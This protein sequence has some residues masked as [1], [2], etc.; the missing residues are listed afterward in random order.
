MAIEHVTLQDRVAALTAGVLEGGPCFAVDVVVRGRKGAHVIDVFVE[1]DTVLD[2]HVL[3]GISRE[4]GYVLDVTDAVP[5]SYTLNVSSPG[6]DRPLRI[7]RQY[8]KMVGRSLR[9]HYRLPKSRY[10]EVVGTLEAADT[11]GI[12]IAAQDGPRSIGYG[13]VLWAKVKLPW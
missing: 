6:A 12:T 3:A 10:T 1:S 13:E 5:G 2:A 9:V 4:L 8:R 11:D 7:P